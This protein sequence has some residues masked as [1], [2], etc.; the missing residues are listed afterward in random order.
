MKLTT[1]PK[2]RYK[3]ELHMHSLHSAGKDIFLDTHATVE[4]VV[5]ACKAKDIRIFSITDHDN[6]D[7]HKEAQYWA[8]KLDLLFIPGCEISTKGGDV[9]AY[10]ITKPLKK[11][12][13][14]REVLRV[15]HA[16]GGVAIAAH[17]FQLPMGCTYA[18]WTEDFDAVE[19]Y[20]AYA[21][22]N[23]ITRLANRL[24]AQ[25]PS[26][27]GSDAHFLDE[28]G[29]VYTLFPQWVKDITTF[30]KAIQE[31]DIAVGGKGIG[32]IRAFVRRIKEG[33]YK[34]NVNNIKLK[35]VMH[36]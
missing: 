17:P 14:V 22:G 13:S 15:I 6:L 21:V 8:R 5:R 26:V 12:L 2:M 33:R 18:M 34:D 10:G 31:N 20:H 36:N 16:Q 27:A 32:L 7:S 29:L 19:A 1:D 24:F 4:N 35:S 11:D 28:I 25:K 3:A 23:S 9:L 30:K